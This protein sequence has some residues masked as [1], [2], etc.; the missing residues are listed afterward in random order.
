MLFYEFLTLL[1]TYLGGKSSRSDFFN[2]LIENSIKNPDDNPLANISDDTVNRYFSSKTDKISKKNS[3][4]LLNIIQVPLLTA[5]ISEQLNADTTDRLEERLTEAGLFNN[6]SDIGIDEVCAKLF[7]NYLEQLAGIATPTN[8]LISVSDIPISKVYVEN[9]KIIIGTE[10]FTLPC[11]SSIPDNIVD[12]ED[13]YCKQ[14]LQ[15]YSENDG[16]SKTDIYDIPSLPTRYKKHLQDQRINYFNA[17]Y[18]LRTVKESFKDSSQQI[19]ILKQETYD[20]VSDYLF[21]D[22]PSA[23]KKISDTLKHITTVSFKKP[24]ITQIQNFIG[25]SEKKG[26]CHTLVNDGKFSWIDENE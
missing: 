12:V 13:A 21:D 15:A 8:T 5:Y 2:T 18:V 25:N 16:K 20:S 7:M 10:S 4:I 3:I 6:S 11:K 24:E 26:L 22:Y 19:E 17:D 1:H 9:G 14:L 23:Y